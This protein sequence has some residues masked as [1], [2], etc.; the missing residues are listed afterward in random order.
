M[1]YLEQFFHNRIF[2]L[3]VLAWLIAQIIKTALSILVEHKLDIKRILGLGGMPSSHSAV[4]ATL[5]ISVGRSLGF[6]S[7][8]FAIS[9]M[10]A[11][12]VMTDAAGIRRAAGNQARALNIIIQEM[13][14]SDPEASQDRLKELLGHSPLE[15]AVG[16]LLGVVIA[17]L[18][19]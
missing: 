5:S 3:C 15:V 13:F 6:D 16:A 14:T 17:V 12:V 18:F 9:A 19:G 4:T 7:I 2:W 1:I 10:L 11:M 8:E